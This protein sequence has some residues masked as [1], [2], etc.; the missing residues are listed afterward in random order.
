MRANKPGQLRERVS[1]V[2][3]G[4][5]M[6]VGRK[7][8]RIWQIVAKFTHVNTVQQTHLSFTFYFILR[9]PL[10][11]ALPDGFPKRSTAISLL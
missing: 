4:P 7:M 9:S 6:M 10:H 8:V 5:D 11:T 1:V 2:F 3:G